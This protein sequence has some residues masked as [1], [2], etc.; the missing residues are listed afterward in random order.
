M[1]TGFACLNPTCSHVFP[2]TAQGASALTCP[3]CGSVFQFRAGVA[4]APP[5]VPIGRPASPPIPVSRPAS[6]FP[7]SAPASASP[8]MASPQLKTQAAGQHWDAQLCPPTGPT[9]AEA[10]DLDDRPLAAPRVQHR[11]SGW[12]LMVIVVGLGGGVLGG[13]GWFLTKGGI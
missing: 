5:S 13:V 12:L 7:V 3:K 9:T 2:A 8:G 11:G 4:P 1:P 10:F 6:S